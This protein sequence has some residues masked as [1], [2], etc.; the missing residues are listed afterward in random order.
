MNI[1]LETVEHQYNNKQLAP[2]DI[3]VFTD[4]QSV[5]QAKAN[6]IFSD[7]KET[8]L[9]EHTVDFLMNTY[10]ISITFQWIPGHV[11]ISGNENADR[12]ARKG[13]SMDQHD[14]PVNCDTMCNI[15]RNNFK[16]NG[17]KERLGEKCI[18]R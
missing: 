17:H 2:T 13:A 6:S 4:S 11:G 9:L 7:L 18:E 8:T 14:R 3:V 15:L 12:L 16:I 10:N 5:L 1:A